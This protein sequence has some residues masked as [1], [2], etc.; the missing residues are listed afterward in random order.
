MVPHDAQPE[1]DIISLLEHDYP[2]NKRYQVTHSSSTND[3]EIKPEIDTG[4][5]SDSCFSFKKLWK[6]TGPGML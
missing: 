4:S 6:Y 5:V 3:L 2:E 1:D